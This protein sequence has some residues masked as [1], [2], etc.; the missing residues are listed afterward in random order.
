MQHGPVL[1]GWAR[2]EVRD[3]NA[4]GDRLARADPGRQLIE[5]NSEIGASLV[6]QL[7]FDF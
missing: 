1:R 7:R 3:G 6:T 5:G 4:D 2:A